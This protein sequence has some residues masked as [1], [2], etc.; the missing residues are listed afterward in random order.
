MLIAREKRKQNI[1]EYIL[2]LWQ[3]E[4]TIRACK[5]NIEMIEERVISQFNVSDKQRAE[6]KDWYANLILMMHEEGIK[7]KGHLMI[8]EDLVRDL[9]LLHNKL[10][11]VDKDPAYIEQYKRAQPNIK[12]FE[13]KL[14]DSTSS[15]IELCLSALYGLLL[16][17]LQKKQI[18][19]E[20]LQAMQTFS[21]LL[22]ILSKKYKAIGKQGDKKI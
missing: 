21:N 12:Y 5:F 6:I 7:T 17:R 1:A 8:L 14:S 4:D 2:Y 22:A 16:L 15:E 18:S 3:I 19:Q 10:I 9:E 13:E 11:N 20:T